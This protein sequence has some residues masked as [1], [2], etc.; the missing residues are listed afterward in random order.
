M[1]WR[2]EEFRML[3]YFMKFFRFI[4]TMK[5]RMFVF[6]SL[7]VAFAAVGTAVTC[8]YMMDRDLYRKAGMA[9]EKSM[10][11]FRVLLAEKGAGFRVEDGKLLVGEHVLNGDDDVVDRVKRLTG[12]AAT[13]F[14]GDTRV[15]TNIVKEDGA[16]ATGTK[17]AAPVREALFDR[18][19]PFEGETEVLG[20]PYITRYEPIRDAGGKTIGALSVG[21]PK[22]FFFGSFGRIR[23]AALAVA[24]LMAVFFG[25]VTFLSVRLMI[26]PL[27]SAAGMAA[28]FAQGDLTAA[29]DRESADTE[30]VRQI[31]DALDGLG[32]RL[33]ETFGKMAGWSH[34]L[35]SAAEQLSSTTT[36]IHE[37]NRQVS[38]QTESVAASSEQMSATVAQA[39]A[40]THSVQDASEKALEAASGGAVAIDDFLGAMAG[41]RDVVERSAGTVEAVGGRA[42]E[43]GGVVVLINDIADQTNLLALNAAIEAARAGENGRGFAVVADEV[44]KLAEK[45]QQATAQ[46][47][48]AIG[49]VQ[50][51]SCGAVEAM[52]AGREAVERSAELG[53]RAKAAMGLIGE[54]VRNSTD[55]NRRIAAATEELSVTIRDF[56][57]N[58]ERVSQAVGE[59]AAGASEIAQT[60]GMVA[61]KAEE[62]RSSVAGFRVR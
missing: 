39:A 4:K 59:N 16:R 45:T 25:I 2:E 41:I 56:S 28:R 42:K 60:A 30:E 54:R 22:S 50:E 23:L 62:L 21:E 31:V 36:R 5:S 38:G 8:L 24:G 6:A 9:Q 35:A 33:R 44:R 14:L 10:N 20:V 26:A 15:S 46:I 1:H 13:V 53:E 17:L 52:R 34:E 57:S 58:I 61:R 51:E 19:E 3:A 12:G 32:E 37:A 47:S 55:Q 7:A 40:N 27:E 29:M 43:I 48:K 18:G 11:V 49:A